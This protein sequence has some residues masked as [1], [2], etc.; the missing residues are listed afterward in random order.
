MLSE[1]NVS[2]KINDERFS[3]MSRRYEEE[4][5]ELAERIKE[6]KTE[7]DKERGKSMTTDMFIAIVRKYTRAKKLTER[8]LNELIERI[9]VHQAEKVEGEHRQKLTIQYNCVG[10]IQ[11]PDILPLPLPEVLIQTRNLP[12]KVKRYYEKS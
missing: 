12:I 7:L 8:M 11:I 2:G 1:D 3:R 9:E 6:L 5:K 10:S 4:Q